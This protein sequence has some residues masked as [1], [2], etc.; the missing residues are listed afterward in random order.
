MGDERHLLLIL[1]GKALFPSLV[2]FLFSMWKAINLLASLS[3]FTHCSLV[4]V[5]PPDTV[6]CTGSLILSELKVGNIRAINWV[7]LETLAQW[8]LSKARL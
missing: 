4:A 3:S 1:V 5:W 6:L 7:P 2:A 8:G